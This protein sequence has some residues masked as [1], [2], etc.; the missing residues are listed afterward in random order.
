MYALQNVN[1][2]HNVVLM[3]VYVSVLFRLEDALKNAMVDL[4]KRMS[5]IKEALD[6]SVD[7]ESVSKN[8]LIEDKEKML[9]ELLDLVESIDQAK[10]LSTIG[11][12][13][14]LLGV[15][16][17]GC[18]SLQWRGAEII[19]TCAQNNPQVQLSFLQ[20]GVMAP[21]MELLDSEDKMCR[22]KGL[23]AISC[24]IRGCS[25]AHA[26]FTERNGVTKMIELMGSS[27]GHARIVRKCLQIM[28][29]A[30]KNSDKDH[31][32]LQQ[33]AEHLVS[34]L[35][36]IVKEEEDEDLRIMALELCKAMG[37]TVVG[38]GN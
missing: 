33:H 27:E 34:V 26:W 9:D 12:L 30:Y 13:S 16:Q 28:D 24:M 15:I 36:R 17:G 32:E 37:T 8:S 31:D 7:D 23:F 1:Y 14:T 4:S 2:L 20:G 6:T 19:G 10:D 11:G 21:L 3:V 18:P 25:Q 22:L 29:Y 38:S 5:D 35:T